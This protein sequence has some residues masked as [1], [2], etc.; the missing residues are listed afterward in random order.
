MTERSALATDGI[1]STFSGNIAAGI[2]TLSGASHVSSVTAVAATVDTLTLSDGAN[3]AVL[4]TTKGGDDYFF[5]QGGSAGTSDDS[6]ISLGA[7]SGDGLTL[8][9]TNNTAV[10]TFSGG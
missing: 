5:V 8:V 1:A 7:L 4:F 2:V 6:I 10:I 9:A 3:E